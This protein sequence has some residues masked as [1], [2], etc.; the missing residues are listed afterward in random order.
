MHYLRLWLAQAVAA[1][2]CWLSVVESASSQQS[3]P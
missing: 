2:E 3:K 1:S